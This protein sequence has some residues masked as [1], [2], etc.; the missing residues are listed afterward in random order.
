MQK[1]TAMEKV[2][3]PH[4]QDIAIAILGW[5]ANEP[6]LLGRFLALSGVAPA[7]LRQRMAEPGFQAGLLDF[8]MEHE[9]DLIAF[10]QS[11]GLAPEAVAAAWAKVSRPGL[12]S[13]EY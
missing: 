11:A 12:S 4:T 3:A 2:I 6:D 7:E 8:V 10:C 9:P 1:K 13:G 5:L